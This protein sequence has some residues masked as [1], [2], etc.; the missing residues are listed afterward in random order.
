MRSVDERC[1][2][3]RSRSRKISRHRR[4][5]ALV[6]MVVLMVIPL[7]DLAGRTA[8]GGVPL[9]VASDEGLFGAVSLFGSSVGGY[10]LVAL[11]GAAVAALIT[12]ICISR[13][14]LSRGNPE[15]EASWRNE[16]VMYDTGAPPREA[17]VEEAYGG[18]EGDDREHERVAARGEIR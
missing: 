17:K 9:P 10:V 5:R 13:R 2:I 12:A 3:V 8:T 15:D 18:S 14:R 11:A 7:L 16:S 1:A 6:A 4:D